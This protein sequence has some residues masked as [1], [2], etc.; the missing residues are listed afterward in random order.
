MSRIREIEELAIDHEFYDWCNSKD[1]KLYWSKF[2]EDTKCMNLVQFFVY[3]YP[4]LKIV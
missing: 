3:C 1:G 2:N 4:N